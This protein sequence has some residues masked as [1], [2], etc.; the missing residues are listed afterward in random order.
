MFTFKVNDHMSTTSHDEST[1]V[2]LI[3][4]NSILF[5]SRIFEKR[6]K[7]MHITQLAENQNNEW[8]GSVIALL[9][10]ICQGSDHRYTQHESSVQ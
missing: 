10:M 3:T 8:Y 2:V 4:L 1:I 9:A 6:S 7:Q 5:L